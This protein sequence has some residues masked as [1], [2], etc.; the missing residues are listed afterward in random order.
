MNRLTLLALALFLA[1]CRKDDVSIASL[2]NNPFD[3]DFT[4]EDLFVSEGTE[5]IVEPIPGIGAVS[6]QV[7]RFRVRNE[8]FLPGQAGRP[9]SVRVVDR[10]TGGTTYLDQA[11]PGDHRFTYLLAEPVP[12]EQVCLELRLANNFSVARPETICEI[13]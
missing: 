4:G 6:R 2:N 13:L 9:Y 8:L 7:I 10:S 3:A 11:G 1:G 5:L 12:A